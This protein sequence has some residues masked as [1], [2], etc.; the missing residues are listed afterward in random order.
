MSLLDRV[1][2]NDWRIEMFSL[3]FTLVFVLLYKWGDLYNTKL[4]SSFLNG[5][6]PVMQKNFFQYGVSPTELYKKDLSE[7]FASYLSGRQNI[8]RVNI[9]VLLKPRHNLFMWILETLLS[10][11]SKMVEKPCDRAEIFIY[12]S[13]VYDNFI[14]AIVNKEGMN[15]ARQDNYYLS[16]T[17]TSDSA[18]LPNAFVYMSEA[19]EFYE[20]VFDGDLLLKLDASV[21]KYVAITDQP[22]ERAEE[23]SQLE[24]RRRIIVLLNI[25][26]DKQKLS[27][28]GEFMDSLFDV[29]DALAAKKIAFRPELLRK[30]LKTREG[31]VAKLQKVIDDARKEELAQERAKQKKG[32]K[33]R[34]ELSDAEQA[35]LEKKALEKKQRKQMKKLRVKM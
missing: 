11:F 4:A 13:V 14:A 34:S 2:L 20:K 5:L 31:E 3:G 7:S 9:R 27:Q 22:I 21:L 19:S 32:G 30:V 16:L 15:D 12:P 26:N 29:I 1:L 28:L 18:N 33:K 8:E 25:T 23:I 6:S 24:P 10:F 17:K 35:K